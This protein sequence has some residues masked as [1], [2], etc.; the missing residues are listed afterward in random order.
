M[1]QAAAAAAA[2]AEAGELD[3]ADALGEIA[4]RK[5]VIRAPNGTN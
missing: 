4:D 2:A 1:P 3:F 5:M